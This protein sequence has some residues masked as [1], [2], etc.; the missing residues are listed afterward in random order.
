[1]SIF[2]G[3]TGL[4][5]SGKDTLADILTSIAAKRGIQ[6]ICLKLSDEIREDALNSG[7]NFEQINRQILIKIGN[8]LRST[9]G[10]G[11]LAKRVLERISTKLLPLE[12]GVIVITGIR[13]PEEVEVF[14]NEL[15]ESFILIGVDADPSVR[16]T[17]KLTRKQYKEDINPS[18]DIDKADEDI[19]IKT[20]IEMSQIRFRNNGTK[21]E[22]IEQAQGLFA[23]YTTIS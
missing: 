1:M 11:I 22:L 14:R 16:R 20:C 9:Y 12:F 5:G 23:R 19:G 6:S 3:I 17:R 15:Q 21:E 7:I 4:S 8:Y 2:V 10:G 18:E 13:N